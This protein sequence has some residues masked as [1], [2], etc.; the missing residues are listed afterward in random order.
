M[1]GKQQFLETQF[2]FVRF[3]RFVQRPKLDTPVQ[4]RLEAASCR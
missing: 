4:N 3:G 2:V 1:L